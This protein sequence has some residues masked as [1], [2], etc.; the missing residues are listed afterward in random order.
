MSWLS[1]RVVE[2]EA[3]LN[4]R[5]NTLNELRSQIG[6]TDQ[7]ALE[8]MNQQLQ[9]IRDRVAQTRADLSVAQSRV[10]R[11]ENAR[12]TG[13]IQ[14]MAEAAGD[15]ALQRIL[16]DDGA[17][18]PE[19]RALF[20][21]RYAQ[22]LQQARDAADRLSRQQEALQSSFSQLEDEAEQRA[23]RLI[24]LQQLERDTE[25]TRTLYETFLTR[26][27]ETSV[28]RGLQQA[29]SRILSEALPGG[30][31]EPRKSRII[32]MAAL[33]GVLIG[34]AFV[35]YRQFVHHGVRSTEE[36]E[37]ITGLGVIGQAPR[38]PVKRR[39]Q[40]I[41]Y[42]NSSPTSAGVE[43]IRNIRTSIMLSNVD[44]PPQVIMLSSAVPGEGK[45]TM[46]VSLAHNFANLGKRVIIV[47]CDLRRRTL[48]NYFDLPGNTSGMIAALD[49]R[50]S[51]DDV[52]VK[53]DKLAFD[54]LPGDRS[55]VNAAD[56][57]ASQKFS[58]LI[59]TLREHYD[60]VILDTPPVLIVPDAR[61]VGQHADATVLVVKWNQT[62]RK[63]IQ[64]AL[65][66]LRSGDV[67]VLGTVLSQIDPRG[68]KRYGY[69]GRYGAYSYYAKRYY[70][71]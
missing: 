30:Y 42:L 34:S 18:S 39:N 26:L 21:E 4:E 52:I 17:A 69:A 10:E 24:E 12:E 41:G 56:I 65:R 66:A 47:E 71:T 6:V 61:V 57:L 35:L 43:A 22:V 37:E 36:L 60:I 3:E 53:G 68:L 8:A 59:A 25:A 32:V 55:S 16:G 33:F 46:S 29:D 11:L 67:R 54:V 48:L 1:E 5:E 51:L 58:D 38:F 28:Q 7:A 70:D 20:G 31:V 15:A 62:N 19:D 45:T 63:M 49:G 23:S 40:L 2:L 44:H 64:D 14:T 50:K 9:S 13:D 27:K